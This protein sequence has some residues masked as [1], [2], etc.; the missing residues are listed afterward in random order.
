MIG[1]C[2]TRN[3][4]TFGI[5]DRASRDR[6]HSKAKIL[7][8]LHQSVGRAQLMIWNDYANHWP[9]RRGQNRIRHSHDGHWDVRVDKAV[10]RR[11][12]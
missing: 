9:Q 5:N 8:T 12:V 3:H 7:D 10:Y 2:M 4:I 11:W 1:Q 6:D